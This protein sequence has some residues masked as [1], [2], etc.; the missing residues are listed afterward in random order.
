MTSS[1]FSLTSETICSVYQSNSNSKSSNLDKIVC[2]GQSWQQLSYQMWLVSA[3]VTITN[4][5][6]DTVLEKMYS[7]HATTD[8]GTLSDS[9]PS[10]CPQTHACFSLRS[11]FR[12][13]LA[14][15]KYPRLLVQHG[16]KRKSIYSLTLLVWMCALSGNEGNW[17]TQVDV[18]IV[19]CYCPC[20]CLPISGDV[21]DCAQWKSVFYFWQLA[22][23][24]TP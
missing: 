1:L 20:H 6:L 13:D 24:A 18:Q 17:L 15:K 11:W 19:R 4:L 7:V 10:F 3:S 22:R 2:T 8:L 9:S 14:L 23:P 21:T 12:L 16:M 5:F